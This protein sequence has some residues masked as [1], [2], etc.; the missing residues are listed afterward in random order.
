MPTIL[1][2]Y[3]RQGSDPLMGKA[4]LTHFLCEANVITSWLAG[5]HFGA[6]RCL[7]ALVRVIMRPAL[8]CGVGWIERKSETWAASDD[9]CLE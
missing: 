3:M 2:D 1:F 4:G 6:P 9:R 8:S 5:L 7:K